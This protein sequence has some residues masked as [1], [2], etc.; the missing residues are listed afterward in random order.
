MV[1]RSL[2]GVLKGESSRMGAKSQVSSFA[3]K[4]P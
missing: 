4:N 1:F 3:A 2:R